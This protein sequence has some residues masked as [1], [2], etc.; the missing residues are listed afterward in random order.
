MLNAWHAGRFQLSWTQGKPLVMGIV[1]ATPDSFSDG[2]CFQSTQAAIEQARVLLNEGAD[3]LDVGG[4]STR[5]GAPPVT[6]EEEWARIG[7]VLQELVTWNVPISVDTMRPETMR[8]ALD[9]G[10]DILNDVYAFRAEGALAV[11]AGSQAGAV[12]MHMQGEPQTMQAN[13]QYVRVV[14]EVHAFL[15]QRLQAL[16]DL[17]VQGQRVLVDQG[18]G[19][20]KTLAHN[21]E[22]MQ[23]VSRFVDLGAGVLVGVSRKR[24]I[25]DLLGEADP[26]KR[27]HGSVAAALFAAQQGAAVVRVHDMKATCDALAVMKAF[28]V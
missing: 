16:L 7:P 19:F 22:L 18:F 28:S 10:V 24:M 8:R 4:E 3:I 1:N 21:V 14:D 25:G 26:M 12:V 9:V 13:P 17:G 23:Q 5:P 6:P 15:E 11:L 2:G 27:V 20:G